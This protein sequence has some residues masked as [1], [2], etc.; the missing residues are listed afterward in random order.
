MSGLFLTCPPCR[1]LWSV[2]EIPSPQNRGAASSCC[3]W[4]SF[5]APGSFLELKNAAAIS[6]P[7]ALHCTTPTY[8]RVCFKHDRALLRIARRTLGLKELQLWDI[9]KTPAPLSAPKT[10]YRETFNTEPLLCNSTRVSKLINVT[11][12]SAKRRTLPNNSSREFI[13]A[14]KFCVSVVSK[15]RADLIY[16]ITHA[17]RKRYVSPKTVQAFMPISW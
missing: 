13:N 7:R 6:F 17:T 5:S 10:S 1:D 8:P 16:T 9:F 2:L 12:S 14:N 15:L 3:W 4:I 11:N